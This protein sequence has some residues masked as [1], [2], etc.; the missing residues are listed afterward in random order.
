MASK[1]KAAEMHCAMAPRADPVAAYALQSCTVLVQIHPPGAMCEGH[2]GPQG[3]LWTTQ[4]VHPS[5]RCHGGSQKHCRQGSIPAGLSQKS[6]WEAEK[7][8]RAARQ[9]SCRL[10]PSSACELYTDT[11]QPNPAVE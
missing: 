7:A 6:A 9:A 8:R 5:Q 11:S 1:A 4:R 10:A 2:K 3:L